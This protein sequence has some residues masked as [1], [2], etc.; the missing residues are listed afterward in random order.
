MARL[1][2]SLCEKACIMIASI[3][4]R[5]T[6][7][8]VP[9][10]TAITHPTVFTSNRSKWAPAR[11]SASARWAVHHSSMPTRPMPQCPKL[12][13]KYP[14][15]YV[16]P[17]QIVSRTASHTCRSDVPSCHRTK[18][19]IVADCSINYDRARFSLH[20]LPLTPDSFHTEPHSYSHLASRSWGR[21]LGWEPTAPNAR[22]KGGIRSPDRITPVRAEVGDSG[23]RREVCCVVMSSC[24]PSGLG[25][26]SSLV[27]FRSDIRIE[28]GGDTRIAGL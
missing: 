7:M 5:K 8:T 15:L 16:T 6:L 23:E 21:R 4:T 20:Q 22:G 24:L 13:I 12:P 10:C 28:V 3:A 19:L 1:P 14:L 17:S 11:S 18:R 2:A 25:V 9:H 27:L 26:V